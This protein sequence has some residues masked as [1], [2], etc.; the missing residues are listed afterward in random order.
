V[1]ID[2]QPDLAGEFGIR[3]VPTMVLITSEGVE[4]G[5]LVG[6]KSKADIMEWLS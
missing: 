5:R 1:D 4:Q 3:G 6:G 2:A